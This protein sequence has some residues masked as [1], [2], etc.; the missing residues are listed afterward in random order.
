MKWELHL[1]TAPTSPCGR[2]PAAEGIAAF[3]A[4]GYGGV[5]VTDHYNDYVM[6]QLTGTDAEKVET[7]LAG[8]R[9]AREAGER[10]GLRVLF[11][12]EAHS[13]EHPCHL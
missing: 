11:G 9:A 7:W 8:Y 1:H 6:D 3:A 13:A 10:W 5:V 4:S 12:L 2:V